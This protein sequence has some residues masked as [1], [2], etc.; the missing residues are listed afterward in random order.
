MFY[1]KHNIGPRGKL[2]KRFFAPTEKL[3][4]NRYPDDILNENISNKNISDENI[5]KIYISNKN[6]SNIDISKV[7]LG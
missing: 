3:A 7:R 2:F 6:I 5:S 1:K 4:P